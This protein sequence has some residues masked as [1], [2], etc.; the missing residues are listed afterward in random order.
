MQMPLCGCLVSV[1][2]A[3]F[4]AGN[5]F[6]R[7]ARGVRLGRGAARVELGFEEIKPPALALAE[8]LI[9]E[10][11]FSHSEL[12]YRVSIPISD[13]GAAPQNPTDLLFHRRSLRLTTAVGRGK[14]RVGYAIVPRQA[15][16][17][18]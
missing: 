2:D 3:L 14:E 18:H 7:K 17:I 12:R 8:F 13:N 4:L 15:F 11:T 9:Q 1:C 5:P 16:A 6:L 10:S